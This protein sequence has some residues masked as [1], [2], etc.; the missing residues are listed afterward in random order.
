[1]LSELRASDGPSSP[2]T[3]VGALEVFF[4]GL[5]EESSDLPVSPS[6]GIH[7]ALLNIF[8]PALSSEVL[9]GT[10]SLRRLYFS[11][12]GGTMRIMVQIPSFLPRHG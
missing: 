6:G 3:V 4:P 1:M 8:P 5:F 7:L 10:F 2:P 9:H 12:S 11:A